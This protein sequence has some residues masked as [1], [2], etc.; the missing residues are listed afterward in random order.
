MGKIN[1]TVSNPSCLSKDEYFL[2]MTNR[3]SPGFNIAT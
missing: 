3:I 2:D 1:K